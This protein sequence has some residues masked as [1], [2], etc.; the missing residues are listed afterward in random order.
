MKREHS[1]GFVVAR[2]A[3]KRLYLLL[4]YKTNYWDFPKGHLERDETAKEAAIRELKE[5]TG[6]IKI[7]FIPDFEHKISYIF[8]AKDGTVIYKDVVFFLALTPEEKVHISDE[9]KGYAWLCYEDAIKRATY[10]NAKE[11]IE[12]AEQTLRSK[13]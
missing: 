12:K 9:H 10:K 8:T 11:L 1:A 3:N 4:E 6:I 2:K 13:E 7:E 5:E